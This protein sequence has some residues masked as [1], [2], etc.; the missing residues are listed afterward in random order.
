[1]LDLVESRPTDWVFADPDRPRVLSQIWGRVSSADTIAGAR[2][3]GAEANV[4]YMGSLKLIDR[5]FGV[6]EMYDLAADPKESLNLL[7]HPSE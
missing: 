4:I 6:D 7:T 2:A 1:M 5:M 3:I